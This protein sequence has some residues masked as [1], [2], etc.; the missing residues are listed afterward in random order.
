[1]KKRILI[2]LALTGGLALTG[3]ATMPALASG[4]KPS[5]STASDSPVY[6]NLYYAE[7]TVS[8][9]DSTALTITLTERK[10]TTV[11]YT[12]SSTATITVDKKVTA[13]GDLSTGLRVLITGTPTDG[14]MTA[15]A[16]AGRTTKKHTPSTSASPS[17]TATARS[18]KRHHHHGQAP[19]ASA[20]PTAAPSTTPTDDPA[21]EATPTA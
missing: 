10:S 19:S 4:K 18:G 6:E 13:L 16:I 3:V 1:V 8:A 7:G 20:T 14:T 21:P 15:T 12:V 11:T 17:S 5:G 9:V 2:S